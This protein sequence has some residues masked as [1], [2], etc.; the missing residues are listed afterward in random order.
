MLKRI[1]NYD[2][3]SDPDLIGYTDAVKLAEQQ[4]ERI[5]ALNEFSSKIFND[6][7]KLKIS[8]E[9][10]NSLRTQTLNTI[11][12]EQQSYS[13]TEKIIKNFVDIYRKKKSQKEKEK[14]DNMSIDARLLHDDFL[15]WKYCAEDLDIDESYPDAYNRHS[16]Y[17]NIFYEY[18]SFNKFA[19]LFEYSKI[20]PYDTEKNKKYL[21]SLLS[22]IKSIDVNN[23]LDNEKII[24]S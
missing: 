2:V 14:Y 7:C 9:K 24:L 17:L 19:E 12:I 20:D 22:K 3:N 13:D 15:V 4:K 8:K 1:F 11:N 16:E 21:D 6:Y 10:Y 18:H 5:N 23:I